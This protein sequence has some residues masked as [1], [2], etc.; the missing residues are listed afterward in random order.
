MQDASACLTAPDF[1]GD[2]VTRS[3]VRLTTVLVAALLVVI[4]GRLLAGSEDGARV[5]PNSSARVAASQDAKPAGNLDAFM[6]RVLEHRDEAWRKLH[7]YVL[8]ETERFDLTGP[9]GVRLHGMRR[10]FT[11][12]VRDGYLIRSPLRFDG[13]TIPEADRRRY[14]ENWLKEEQGR[15]A[16]RKKRQANAGEQQASTA[17]AGAS[18]APADDAASVG[19]FVDER[20]E[21][22]FISESFFLKFKFEAGNYYLAGRERLDGRDVVRIEYYPTHLE[23][24]DASRHGRRDAQR[25][26]KDVETERR[27]ERDL[28]KV[29][30]VTL[31]VDPSEYQVMRYRFDNVDFGFLPARWL[32][33]VD[34]ISAT[35]TMAKVLDGVWLPHALDAQGGVTLATGS[36]GFHYGRELHDY[37][38]A[39]TSAK[40][41]DIGK[42]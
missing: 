38:K 2:I 39:E 5:A 22:R 15:E 36:Y 35:M 12:Y 23:R 34:S 14:E 31:W 27:L 7:D 19:G 42:E 11:W 26:Q 4:G 9:G 24:V 29:A 10:E 13:V 6:A 21:P 40:I 33:R 25:S 17:A 41:R 8:S 16:R 20:G 18:G 28:N 30:V 3:H 1:P 37:K 32:V